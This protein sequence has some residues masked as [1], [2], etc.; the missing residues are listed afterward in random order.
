MNNEERA[1]AAELRKAGFTVFWFQSGPSSSGYYAIHAKLVC[2]YSIPD[3]AGEAI[4]HLKLELDKIK[5]ATIQQT[6]F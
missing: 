1:A 2:Q 5:E 3:K 6:L 4:E